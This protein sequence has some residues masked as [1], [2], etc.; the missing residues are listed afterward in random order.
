M[1]ITCLLLLG[2]CIG[3]DL[4]F[5][6]VPERVAILNPIDTLA[7]GSSYQFVAAYYDRIGRE[8]PREIGWKS[9][10]P[11]LIDIQQD[12]LA[13]GVQAGSTYVVAFAMGEAV[14]TVGDTLL[15]VVGDTTT[16]SLS[17]RSGELRTTSSYTLKGSF[18]LKDTA[19]SL[20]L[21]LHEDY[22]AS[23]NLPGLYLYLTNNPNSVNDALEVGAVKVFAGAHSYSLPTEVELH[24]YNYLLYYCKPFRVKVGDGKLE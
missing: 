1:G 16:A 10:D 23:S 8:A 20:L 12:G 22:Q 14:Q 24:T 21:Q 18:T 3:D 5:D 15:V 11:A 9:A 19:N 17:S 7:Q 4:I 2:G 6:T 13:R